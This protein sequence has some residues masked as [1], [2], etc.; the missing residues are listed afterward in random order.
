MSKRRVSSILLAWPMVLGLRAQTE[1][2]IRT[3]VHVVEVSIVATGAG[4]A[5]AEGLTATDLRV[6]DN[7]QEQTIA[8]FEKISSAAPATAAV[9]PPN[10][11]SNR[12]GKVG[13]PQVLSM[14]LLDAVNTNFRDQ[15]MARHAV[16]TI[17][18]QLRPEE[19]VAIYGFGS[20]FRVRTIHD[21]S[22]DKESLLARFR[23]YRTGAL[24]SND[25]LADL[26]FWDPDPDH[27]ILSGS[28]HPARLLLDK[29]RIV[30]TLKALEAIAD[31]V[32]G[33]P[34]R[35]NLLWVSA[36]FPLTIGDPRSQ[37]QLVERVDP[38]FQRATAALNNANISVY[39]IDARGLSISP[40]AII[41]IGTMR[42]MADATGGKAFYNRNDL[43]TGVREA[44]DDSREIYVL[45]YSPQPMVADGSYHT[46]RVQSSQRGV[47]LRY[48][49]GY[50][51]PDKDEA[52]ASAAP[53]DRLKAVVADPLDASEIAIQATVEQAAD[54]VAL[55]IRVDPADINL[56][57]NAAR[58][59]GALRLEAMQL[60]AA[61]EL[62]GGV[63]QAAKLNLEEA[64]Y[65][66]DLQQG[67]PFEMK[68]RREPAAVAVRIGVVDERGTHTGSVSVPLPPRP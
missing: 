29:E 60:G 22:S 27:S 3:N 67:L 10:T 62:L 49:L 6:W 20:G 26:D 31:R 51:A 41:N 57:P 24:D 36:A 45:T 2:V 32:K 15:Y 35:K 9:L 54:D 4:G 12:I 33:V 46:I 66:R 48:R 25:A 68:F 58:W 34:G 39:P 56:V 44:L 7:G 61:G 55:T 5:P 53:E 18:E 65:Q 14:V 1:A 11:Y 23:G 63:N 37:M 16:E 13:R 40:N 30:N 38:Q 50:Y 59:A 28:P 47:Q 8:S 17:L 43:A 19:R 52:A 42:D 64:T 21:F